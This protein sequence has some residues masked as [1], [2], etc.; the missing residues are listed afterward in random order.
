MRLVIWYNKTLVLEK[1]DIF[2]SQLQ[3]KPEM[4]L[5]VSNG[6]NE[7]KVI[8]ISSSTSLHPFNFV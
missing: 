1:Y 3:K 8:M 7:T 2:L 4:I 5:P 6:A